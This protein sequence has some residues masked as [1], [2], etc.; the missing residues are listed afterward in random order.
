MGK[1]TKEVAPRDNYKAAA[2]KTPSMKAPGSFDGTPA[3]K[4]RGLIQ[5]CQLIFHNDPENFFHDRNKVLYS[6]SFLTGRA[7]K[8]IEPFPFQYF[9]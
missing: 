6:A 7:E 8:W 4:W 9:Q 2:L 5:F 3:H 1:L